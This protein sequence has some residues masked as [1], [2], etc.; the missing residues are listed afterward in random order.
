MPDFSEEFKVSL[1]ADARDIDAKIAASKS[2]V[3]QFQDEA[4]KQ[5]Q[6]KLRLNIAE[7]DKKIADARVK[8]RQFRKEGDE[9]GEIKTRLEIK[10]LQDGKSRASKLLRDLQ[11]DVDGTTKSFFSL[12]GIV[13]DA[14]KAFGGFI[15]IQKFAGAL[16]GA[17]DASVSFESAFTGVR[18]TIDASE[19]E[20]AALSDQFRQLAK[21]IPIPIEGLLQIGEL[22]GQLGVKKDGI[23]D[24][25]KTVA[26]L[27]VTTNLTSESAATAFARIANIYEI[28]IEKTEN[29]ASAVVALGNNFA[30]TES[31]ITDFATRIAGIGKVVGFTSS[32][33]AAIG[34]AFVSVGV[35]AEAGGTAVQKTLISINDAVVNGGAELEKFASVS[36]LTAKDFAAL[37]KSQPVQAFDLFVKGLGK[38]G[39]QA[40]KVLDELVGGDARL[41]RAFLSLAQS[42]DLLTDAINL[43]SDAFA[44]NT[45]LAAEANKF[46]STTEGRLQLLSGRWNDLKIKM[47]DF[48]KEV[49]LPVLEFFVELA[50]ALG[51]AEN[52]LSTVA[53]V[54]KAAGVAL[55]TYFGLSVIKGIVK[56]ISL[57]IAELVALQL[58][59]AR[60]ATASKAMAAANLASVGSFSRLGVLAVAAINPVTAAITAAA[61]AAAIA[62]GGIALAFFEAK[63]ASERFDNSLKDLKATL[64]ELAGRSPNLKKVTDQF[65]ADLDS[66]FAKLEVAKQNV[67]NKDLYADVIAQTEELRQQT[68]AVF[69]SLGA[70]S[71][72]IEQLKN[73]FD[74]FSITIAPTSEELERLKTKL[75]ETAEANIGPFVDR[76]IDDVD[77]IKKGS[78]TWSEA[79]A[80]A[81]EDNKRK[82]KDEVKNVDSFTKSVVDAYIQHVADSGELGEA[83]FIAYNQGYNSE[84]TRRLI[85]LS[86]EEILSNKNA[87][88]LADYVKSE[89]IGA[90]AG[91]LY[92]QGIISDVN[93]FE[94]DASAK[95][96]SNA[97]TNAFN[98]K[99]GE[100]ASSGDAGGQALVGGAIEGIRKKSPALANVVSSLLKTLGSF[101]GVNKLFKKFGVDLLGDYSKEVSNFETNYNDFLNAGGGG[102]GGGGAADALK[103]AEKKAKDA[104]KA[105]DDFIKS[106]ED[107]NKASEK[108]KDD[109]HDFYQDIV[110]SIE[111]A[112]EKQ[113]E[114]KDE[115]ASF[116]QG[117][118]VDFANEASDRSVQLAEDEKDVREQIAE[119]Q[120]ETTET[121]EE[122]DAKQKKLNE[123]NDELNGILKERAQIQEYIAGVDKNIADAQAEYQAAVESGDQARIESAQAALDAAQAVKDAFD[124]ATRRSGLTEFEQAQLELQDRIKAKEAEVQA[125]IDKQEKI[126]EIQKKFLE[127]QEAQ[128]E[129]G[130]KKRQALIDLALNKEVLSREER[131]KALADLGFTDLT[132][133][134]EL[135][136]LQQAERANALDQEA[137]DIEE[138]QQKILDTKEEYFQLAEDA[139]AA[140]VDN[141]VEKT[142]ELIAII[143]EAQEQQRILNSLR[144]Q[145]GSAA[146]SVVNKNVNVVNYNSNDVDAEAALNNTLNKI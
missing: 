62:A 34:T 17:F 116:K 39:D 106:I 102:G 85:G 139:H 42:G 58:N 20:F 94:A 109:I 89:N 29:L 142:E 92:A 32:D 25:T 30:A 52:K 96:L 128:D 120:K 75:D 107:T 131:Q 123:L 117:E 41:K 49:A 133:D 145:A 19:S 16:K 127:L 10:A 5:A 134:Q 122:A 56:G 11:K 70:T 97:V 55:L 48:L 90:T 61:I 4:S 125:E 22:A 1:I 80:K 110:D 115:L 124:E 15:L 91:L 104:E 111:K 100:I 43:S 45:A 21:E 3:K 78:T 59:M 18:K 79:V 95:G 130:L 77:T 140:S 23:I 108:L 38:S 27:S 103:E 2:K 146:S 72:E 118:Q 12:N 136:L 40:S 36:G 76:F 33:I 31:E 14:L 24:F 67:G 51:G 73:E 28:P 81:V 63:A 46:Y 74:F 121:Q 64:D 138:Q 143:K 68:I 8:L 84:E 126:I 93:K 137:K 44:E 37:W 82:Y 60:T 57:L 6:I 112:R 9:V 53:R 7:L 129:E 35:E 69:E 71:E 65:N 98:S 86:A 13:K 135:E 113:A 114:L 88:L 47:G 26:A 99:R 54:I 101:S 87:A 119:L 66:L 105:V 83:A 50:E 132:R 144:G 141:M